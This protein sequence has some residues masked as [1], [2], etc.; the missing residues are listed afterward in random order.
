MSN[1]RVEGQ[2]SGAIGPGSKLKA[3][4]EKRNLTENEVSKSLLISKQIISDL[5]NNDYSRIAALVYA[6]GY[7]KA[8]AEFLE[9]PID[10]ILEEFEKMHVFT[11]QKQ[12]YHSKH[13]GAELLQKNNILSKL[14]NKFGRKLWI[15]AAVVLL[16]IILF[17]VILHKPAKSS[18]ANDE[19]LKAIP[20]E[21]VEAKAV[22]S[23]DQKATT[24]AANITAP[25]NQDAKDA[26]TEPAKPGDKKHET[27]Q[28]INLNLQPENPENA[29]KP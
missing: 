26:Q 17:A 10:S 8:Y 27:S 24:A 1:T 25:A 19:A 18:L 11:E 15:I 23:A 13:A 3:A 28:D 20:V 22:E 2:V 14:H 16:V 29:Q 7:L 5:E 12:T 21:N 9:L 6:R 4:R